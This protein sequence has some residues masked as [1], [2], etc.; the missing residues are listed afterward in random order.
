MSEQSNYETLFNPQTEVSGTAASKVEEY[1]PSAAKG[2][3]NVYQSIIRF[4]PWWKDPKNG[5]M[6]EKW[7][8]WLIDPVTEKGR[9]VDCPTSIGKDSLLLDMYRKL[10]KS[11]SVAMQGKAKI[12]SRRH[13]FAS[14]IQVIKDE[15]NPELEGKILVYRYGVKI[16]DKIKAELKPVIGDVHDPFDIMEGKIFALV[17]TKVSEFNNYDQSKFVDKKIPL[18]IPDQQGK[19]IPITP[20]T[21]K[22]KVFEWVKENSPNLEK[23]DFKPWDSET[24][25]Y[26]NH[27][28]AAVTGQASTASNYASVKNAGGEGAKDTTGVQSP[29][30]EKSPAGDGITATNLNIDDLANSGDNSIDLPDLPDLPNVNNDSPGITGNVDDLIGSL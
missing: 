18:L 27:V 29:K 1:N 21:D 17:I 25:D 2:K 16:H 28:I 4:I 14:L 8:S 30:Q 10:S 13:T 19:L 26:V 20:E 12:F 22:Q 3:N 9:F 7:T 15:N 24:Y 11:E 23:Y 5:S 6:R